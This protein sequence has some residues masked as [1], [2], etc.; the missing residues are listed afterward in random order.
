M[1]QHVG[2]RPFLKVD[3]R[4]CFWLQPQCRMPD[5]ADVR[6]SGVCNAV[7]AL[8]LRSGRGNHDS[9]RFQRVVRQIASGRPVDWIDVALAGGFSD[10]A[11]I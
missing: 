4:H 6:V 3:L 1:P 2:A 8:S 5:Y 7:F 10:Q 9:G 11:R